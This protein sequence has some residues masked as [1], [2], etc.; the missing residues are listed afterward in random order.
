MV[1]D[2]E[3]G[4]EYDVCVDEIQLEHMLELKY[5]GSVL[6]ESGT[7]EAECLNRKMVSGR[8]VADAIRSLVNTRGLKLEYIKVLHKSFL[9][10][11]LM[12]GSEIMLMKEEDIYDY[13]CTHGQSQRFVGY[14][15]N[16]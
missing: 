16:G 11:V 2:G 12:Y 8:R 13:G 1:L 4:L 6:D 15:E 9:M 5:L 7:D 10:P 3:E 14:Q